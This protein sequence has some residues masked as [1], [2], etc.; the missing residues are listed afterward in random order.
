[1]KVR[2]HKVIVGLVKISNR[3]TFFRNNIFHSEKNSGS[4]YFKII[5][6]GFEVLF[7]VVR[8]T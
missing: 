7:F 3:I 2:R 1:M 6:L 4:S 8:N 5:T